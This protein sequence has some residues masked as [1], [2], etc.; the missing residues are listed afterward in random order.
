MVIICIVY[1]LKWCMYQTPPFTE[2]SPYFIIQHHVLPPPPGPHH[3][4]ERVSNPG[5]R[6][7]L[8]R[9]LKATVSVARAPLF[10][11]RRV[12]FTHSPYWHTSVTLTPLNLTPVLVTAPMLPPR[13]R[14]ITPS[15][16]QTRDAGAGGGRSTK[17]A[18]GIHPLHMCNS[19]K[20]T[21]HIQEK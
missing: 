7:V 20:R 18:K 15:G 14:T 9:T 11:V 13:V 6:C 12:R 5:F 4:T 2:Y 19:F 1:K 10:E 21:Q 16:S 8:P 3:H 17:D